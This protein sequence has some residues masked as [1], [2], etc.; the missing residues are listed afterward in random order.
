[1]RAVHSITPAGNS[2]LPRESPSWPV[3]ASDH[4]AVE[5]ATKAFDAH[6]L[7]ALS[8]VLADDVTCRAPGGVEEKGKAAC[9]GFHGRWLADFPDAQLEVRRAGH[10]HRLPIT[11]RQKLERHRL[12]VVQQHRAAFE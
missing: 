3:A 11:G 8:D 12:P 7:H 5:S 9:V 1:M 6:D 10:V 4:D 2:D